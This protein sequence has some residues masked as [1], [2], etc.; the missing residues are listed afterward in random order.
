MSDQE[1]GVRVELLGPVRLWVGSRAVD[2][3]APRPRAVLAVLASHPGSVVPRDDLVAAVW[4]AGAPATAVGNLHTYVSALRKALEP[5]RGRGE[6]W[7]LLTSTGAGYRLRV[8]PGAVDSVE[9]ARLVEQAR[10]RFAEADVH[11]AFA[12]ADAALALWR[13]EVMPGLPGPFVTA[14]R[15]RLEELRTAVVELRAEAGLAAGRHAELVDGLAALVAEHPLRGR[16]RE[17]LMRALHACGRGAEAVDTYREFRA[18]LVDALG[19]EPGPEL[20]RLHDRILADDPAPLIS[21]PGPAAPRSGVPRTAVTGAGAPRAGLSVVGLSRAGLP[22]TAAPR[23]VSR[24]AAVPAAPVLAGRAAELA[25]VEELVRDLGWGRGGRLWVEGEPGIG[26]SALVATVLDRAARA[27]AR[28]AHGVA[29]ELG[30]RFPLGLALDCLD[31]TGRSTDE[32]GAAIWRALR[33]DRA[34]QSV[35]VSI[36]PV[37]SVIEDMVALVAARCAD[38][39]VVLALDDLQWSDDASVVL[40]HRLLRLTEHLPLLLV[41]ATRPLPNRSDLRRLRRDVDA[42]GG[43][44]FDLAPLDD[45][46]VAAVIGDVVGAPPGAGL[47]RVAERAAGNPLYVREIADALLRDG[48]V[49][50]DEGV[51]DVAADSLDRAPRSLVSAVTS[52]LGYLTDATRDVLRWAA[53]LG[54]EFTVGD[55]AAVLGKPVTDVVEPL[56]EAIAAGVLRDAGLRLAFRHPVI[57]QALYEGTPLALRVALHQQAARTLAR[58]GAP[59]EHAPCRCWP[60]RTWP[61]RP[62]GSSPTCPTG[63][64]APRRRW[65]SWTTRWPT[66]P[67]RRRGGRGWCRWWRWCSGRASARSSAPRPAPARRSPWARPRATGSPSA[68]RWRCCGRSTRCGGTTPA[69]SATWTAPWTLWASTSA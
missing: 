43:A 16:P 23:V 51:A 41:G 58:S 25:V 6:P 2:P 39:P 20:R 47:R 29:E 21:A 45:H 40:W 36:D 61:R 18:A 64:R 42:S 4:D 8:A 50:L 22:G 48:V 31:I 38:G 13:G 37:F 44:L 7:R 27:G 12:S 32:R 54:G 62:G 19:I 5:G 11:G 56:D 10:G 3:G 69:R 57:R 35:L 65:S 9:F 1:N 30:R 15:A 34:G 33:D 59:V 67:C 17:L 55:V 68:R 52:R 14:Q 66:R 53:L 26:K 49:R 28:V 46:A 60:T 24:A 63:P